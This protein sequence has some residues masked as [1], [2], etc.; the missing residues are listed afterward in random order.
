[1]AVFDH[2]ALVSDAAIRAAIAIKATTWLLLSL[3]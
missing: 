1:M 3:P 2:V